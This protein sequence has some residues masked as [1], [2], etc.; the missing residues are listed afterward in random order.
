[1]YTMKVK[2]QNVKLRRVYKK[3][4]TIP[5]RVIDLT[6]LIDEFNHACVKEKDFDIKT[7][8]RQIKKKRKRE[9]RCGVVQRRYPQD[10][11]VYK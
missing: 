2:S 6:Y 9:R 5:G 8:E 3:R 11:I 7:N 10:I 4:G 1:M